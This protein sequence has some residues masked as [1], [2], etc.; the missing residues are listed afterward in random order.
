MADR[1]SEQNE[2]HSEPEQSSI[3]CQDT[4]ASNDNVDQIQGEYQPEPSSASCQD[5]NDSANDIGSTSDSDTDSSMGENILEYE[6]TLAEYVIHEGM[7]FRL[8]NRSGFELF[9]DRL[10]PGCNSIPSELTIA[11]HCFNLFR[12]ESK[13]LKE[14]LEK[15]CS[16]VCLAAETW[17]SVHDFKYV[18]LTAHFIDEHWRLQRRML[19]FC[20][21]E[22]HE[23]DTIGSTIK[24]CLLKWGIKKPF[25][26]TVD[27]ASSDV[28]T[29]LKGYLKDWKGLM[30][31]GDY[32]HV[33]CYAHILNMVVTD[34]LRDL[35]DSISAIRNAIRYV[36]L[37]SEG[38]ETFKRLV[39]KEKIESKS[40][41]RLD[42][43]SRWNSTYMM[44]ERAVKFQK[45]FERMENEEKGYK[46]YFKE[47]VDKIGPPT[48][49]DWSKVCAFV[50]FLKIF[51]DVTLR[52]SRSLRLTPNES[53]HDITLVQDM[54]QQKITDEDPL[55]RDMAKNIKRK[56][57]EYWGKL[58]NLNPLLAIAVILDPRYKLDYVNLVFENIYLDAE[59][60]AAM[61][62][63]IKD[64]LYRLYEEYSVLVV[65]E[66]PEN[67]KDNSESSR[68]DA[69]VLPGASFVF[70][71]LKEK[72]LKKMRVTWDPKTELEKYLT[73]DLVD[74]Y[75]SFDILIWWKYNAPKYKVLSLIARDVLAVPASA[76][77]EHVFRP[78]ERV[79]EE[80]KSNLPAKMVEALM[81][82]KNW[83]TAKSVKFSDG[84]FN[85]HEEPEEGD[86][87]FDD[88][89]VYL[90]FE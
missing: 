58:D 50:Q 5:A 76:S 49:S 3:P 1:S 62:K 39:Q 85:Q 51:Y 89:E 36:R 61:K 44:L 68:I 79:L 34:G 26:L 12:E 43:V 30:C 90:V 52:L 16:G 17:T 24:K 67:P 2:E 57:D 21:I 13:K 60:C 82:A 86:S 59:V 69:G 88:D 77:S 32:L 33:R 84:D 45:V 28:I 41:V 35:S 78:R 56:Y 22:D 20:M 80:Y 74:D 38:L 81:C 54:L 10:G 55:I 23:G 31:D 83:L 46:A 14:F 66:P 6:R 25:T 73:A 70:T 7:P 15:S 40:L 63:K 9:W 48:T 72:V 53:F 18:S 75:P 29:H 11:K 42:I 8:A 47:G 87:D 19:N 37:S 65:N 64:T 27:D 71:N 4:G